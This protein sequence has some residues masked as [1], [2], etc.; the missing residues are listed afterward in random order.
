[1][2]DFIARYGRELREAADHTLGRPQRRP[3]FR[4]P[5]RRAGV[6]IVLAAVVVA[7]PTSMAGFDWSPFDGRNDAPSTSDQR[8]ERGLYES[9]AVLRRDQ[10]GADRSVDAEYALKYVGNRT[11]EGAQLDF[12]RVAAAGPSDGVVLVPV[13]KHRPAPDAAPATNEVC[14]WRTDFV[15]GAPEGGSR[16]CYDA[17]QIRRGRALQALGHTVDMLVPDGVARVEGYANGITDQ[18]TP[19]DNVASWQGRPPESVRWFDDR[20]QT[21]AAFDEVP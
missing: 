7:V 5:R 10:R 15:G 1:M 2:S 20:G 21:I 6:A 16:G 14:M 18:A 11:F 8:P 12:V 9:L 17:D 19:V 13:V 3:S 4:G